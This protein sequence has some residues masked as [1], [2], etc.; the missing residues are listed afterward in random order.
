MNF[1]YS[2]VLSICSSGLKDLVDWYT[3]GRENLDGG[4]WNM[5]SFHTVTTISYS[6]TNLF[7][8]AE[9]ENG[10]ETTASGAADCHERDL[11]F[12]DATRL[13]GGSDLIRHMRHF[14]IVCMVVIMGPRLK[15]VS[16][17]FLDKFSSRHI[18][19][20]TQIDGNDGITTTATMKE[21]G[22]NRLNQ[23]RGEGLND[24]NEGLLVS[25]G[26]F[27]TLVSGS[28]HRESGVVLRLAADSLEIAGTIF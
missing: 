4:L 22:N 10:Y 24:T 15:K 2:E 5:E 18:Y 6:K 13:S 14:N 19:D 21:N 1:C 11:V 7:P 27:H 28:N 25:C 12:R 23:N 16:Q 26:T 20:E 8:E 3:G 17:L 9:V